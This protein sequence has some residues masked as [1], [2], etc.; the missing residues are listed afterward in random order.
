M[1]RPPLRL[2]RR[3]KNAIR[4]LLIDTPLM[5]RRQPPSP[6]GDDA[7]PR[8]S[9][10]CP[11]G[12]ILD[13]TACPM[14]GDQ[15]R[16]IV[17]E[18]NKLIVLDWMPDE[19]SARYDHAICH[20]CG[21]LYAS[22]RPAGPRYHWLFEHFEAAIGR[23]PKDDI[24]NLL[25]S[26]PTVTDAEREELRRRAAR[27]V[28]VSDH[29]RTRRSEYLP[30]LLSDRLQVS[31]HAEI[32]GSLLTL[33]GA[34]VLEVRS[35]VGSLGAILKRLYDADVSTM[36]FFERQ[37]VAIEEV[38]GLPARSVIDFDVFTIPY[39][40]RF[41]LITANHMITHAVRP[42][43]FLATLRER[44]TPGGHVY[45]YNEPDDAEYLTEDG[46]SMIR[47]LNPFHV[48]AFDGPSL[49]RALAANG[50]EVVFLH[51]YQGEFVCLC[52][53]SSAPGWPR[54]PAK[55]REKRVAAHQRARDAAVLMLPP[56][57]RQR[58]AGEWE[59]ITERAFAAG[60]AEIGE[61]G[62]ARVRRR[63]GQRAHRE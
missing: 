25:A 26:T 42:R 23:G 8:P 7:V 20:G 56:R 60:I 22:R 57:P 45:F 12:P 33:Q 40:G 30:M 61:D 59:A 11:P 10:P 43:E 19:A 39:E 49:T 28:F 16:T 5:P 58:F 55:E 6:D 3:V 13:V 37:R 46:Q 52:R 14:C 27:G 50:L 1:P 21:I 31:V 2:S 15:G 38:Y 53:L 32:L 35:R 34:R 51:R 17:N 48:Q 9:T 44:L 62:E 24:S 36:A 4:A 29:T 54:M 41:D 63:S 47:R 18:F